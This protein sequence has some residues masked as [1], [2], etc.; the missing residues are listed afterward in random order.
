M[1]ESTEAGPAYCFMLFPIHPR[2]CGQPIVHNISRFGKP[3]TSCM[4]P[5][6][7]TIHGSSLLTINCQKGT[8]RHNNNV[9]HAKS[10]KLGRS[11]KYRGSE[12]RL[13]GG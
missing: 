11:K 5:A 4:G 6:T 3:L 2:V 7:T 12:S 1:T 10:L 13:E 8:A 9:I